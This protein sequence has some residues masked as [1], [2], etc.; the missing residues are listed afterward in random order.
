MKKNTFS[1]LSLIAV[2]MLAAL[3]LK[4]QITYT[5]RL[6]PDN[7]TYK[8]WMQSTTAYTQPLA[9]IPTAQVTVLVPHGTGANAFV[10]SNFQNYQSSM[11]FNGT[12]SR[13][14]APT[15]NTAIDYLSFGFTGATTF[16]ITANTEI[17]LFSFQNSGPC[18]GSLSLIVNATDAFNN[19]PNSTNSNPGNAIT[20]LAK[21]GDAYSS[22]YG[23]PANACASPVANPDVANAPVGTTTNIAV[24]NNDA[25]PNGSAITNLTFI[26]APTITTAPTK[27]TAT[28]KAN[29]TIDYVPN[30]G[31]T[32]S[33]TFSYSICNSSLPNSC[34]TAT[35]TITIVTSPCPSPNCGTATITKN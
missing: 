33:D 18:L 17:A 14:N 32:G 8:V 25:N 31:A 34:S 11:Q 19:L 22:N 12:A 15:E 20:V 1:Q 9:Q 29:G 5:I 7:V 23:T 21:G 24:L 10:V 30:T 6:E 27:G 2:L 26:S 3:Q 4:A 13:V 16:N 28:V 35:A